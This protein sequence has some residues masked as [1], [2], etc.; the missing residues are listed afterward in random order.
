M[1]CNSLPFKWDEARRL[2]ILREIDAVFFHIYGISREDVEYILDSFPIVR[3]KDEGEYGEYRTERVIL[4]IYDEMA[5]AIRTGIPYKTRLDPPPAD[6]RVAHT[7]KE[8]ITLEQLRWLVILRA[9]T[10]I[11]RQK[12]K[13]AL[14]VYSVKILYIAEVCK[15]IAQQYSWT[16]QQHGPYPEAKLFDSVLD[17]MRSQGLITIGRI[18][19][20]LDDLPIHP[21]EAGSNYLAE[22]ESKFKLSD[23]E[24]TIQHIVNDFKQYDGRDME[25]RATLIYLHN[26]DPSWSYDRLVAE[27][28]KEK[29][30]FSKRAS[31]E[32]LTELIMKKYVNESVG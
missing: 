22:L 32:A 30:H 23:Q 3:R 19:S 14:K 11:E 15:Q 8:E 6:P 27:L 29:P 20:Q 16:L 2:Q 10:E 7:A 13:D 4:E 21:T 25:L 28:M 12:K 31:E 18:D 1:G 5:E 26:Q 17:Q 24:Q 9:I